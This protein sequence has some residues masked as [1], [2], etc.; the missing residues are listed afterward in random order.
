M[1]SNI[2]FGSYPV[3][4]NRNERTTSKRTPQFSVGIS[5]KWTYHLPSIRNF[6]NFLSNGKRPSQVPC[7]EVQCKWTCAEE[8]CV[9]SVTLIL[10]KKRMQFLIY[11]S[12]SLRRIGYSAVK[13]KKYLSMWSE[14]PTKH[15][16]NSPVITFVTLTRFAVLLRK[17]SKSE[18]TQ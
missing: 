1:V 7:M 8:P 18:L 15:A 16:S 4:T 9:T 6:Q 13:P 17:L 11:S 3:R 14:L 5:E 10:F 12:L 2:P